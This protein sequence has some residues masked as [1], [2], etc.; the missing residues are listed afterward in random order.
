MVTRALLSANEGL[1]RKMAGSKVHEKLIELIDGLSE[2][3]QENLLDMLQSGIDINRK[4]PRESC[5]IFSKFTVKNR[6]YRDFIKNISPSGLFI[7]SP[8]SARA[9]EKIGLV[10]SLFDY[11]DPLEIT[12]V[13]VWNDQSGFGVR[14]DRPIDDYFKKKRRC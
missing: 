11:E 1:G 9:G 7:E 5:R 8:T 2:K 6:E 12:G 14:F 10:I 3:Q 13:I 4:Q